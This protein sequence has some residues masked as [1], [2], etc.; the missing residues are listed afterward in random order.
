MKYLNTAPDT[1]VPW[2]CILSTAT[3][4]RNGFKTFSFFKIFMFPFVSVPYFTIF[5][6]F[7]FWRL[8]PFPFSFS[9]ADSLFFR[10]WIFLF[11]FLLREITLPSNLRLTTRECMHLGTHGH[12]RSRDTDGGHTIQ[13]AIAKKHMLHANFMASCF[14]EPELLPM[15]VLHCANNDFWL[16]CS[17]HLDLDPMIFIY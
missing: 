2:W 14:T 1:V 9:L 15:K 7:P 16:F 8:F 5:V 3:D 12:F 13:S 6:M 11:P 10:Y 17:C 4:D